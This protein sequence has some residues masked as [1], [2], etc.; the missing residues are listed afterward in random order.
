MSVGK[1]DMEEVVVGDMD[2]VE[3]GESMMIRWRS[4]REWTMID[5]MTG[6]L[7]SGRGN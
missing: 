3:D 5:D 1:E 7:G 2:M 4:Y 6:Q